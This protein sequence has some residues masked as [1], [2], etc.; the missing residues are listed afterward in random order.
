MLV[1]MSAA[2]LELPAGWPRGAITATDYLAFGETEFRTELFEGQIIVNASPMTRHARASLRLAMALMSAMP[3][4]LEV[5][6]D[7]DVDLELAPPAEPGSVL[8]PDLVVI[9]QAAL[10]R[11]DDHGGILR[12]SDVVLAVEIVS[13]TSKRMDRVVKR[14]AYA[15]AEIPNYWIVDL[16]PPISVLAHHRAGEFGYADGGEI[17]GTFRTTEPFGFELELDRLR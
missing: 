3:E 10:T 14:N 1:C 13:P 2:T 6:Q 17:T 4:R 5:L 9:E 12:A 16:D 11:I 8:R 15:D 7:V